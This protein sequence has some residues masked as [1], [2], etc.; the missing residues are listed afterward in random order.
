VLPEAEAE[1]L[2]AVLWYEDQCIGLGEEF[3]DQILSTIE[4]IGKSPLR[5]PLYEAGDNPRRLRRALVERFPYIVTFEFRI[6]LI[7]IVAVAHASQQ[8]GY[9]QAR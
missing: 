2:N 4:A 6:D 3:Y 5:F 9:W 7:L 8:P 1:I